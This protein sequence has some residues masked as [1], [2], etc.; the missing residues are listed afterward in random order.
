[1]GVP[2]FKNINVK[3]YKPGKSGI[4]KSKKYIKLSANES[5]LG[6]SDGVRK[7][8]KSKKFIIN[9]YPDSKSNVLRKA[10]QY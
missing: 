4:N 9:R 5:S 8:F 1:M 6:M 7:V 3:A 2:K 10:M